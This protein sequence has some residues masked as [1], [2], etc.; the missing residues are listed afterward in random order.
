MKTR[1]ML[2]GVAFW[3][4]PPCRPLPID[5]PCRKMKA[6]CASVNFDLF[7]VL[8]RPTMSAKLEFSS[9]DRS[10]KPGSCHRRECGLFERL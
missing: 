1:T 4:R 8:P 2:I 7:M 6:I 10:R 9:K 3:R 5:G